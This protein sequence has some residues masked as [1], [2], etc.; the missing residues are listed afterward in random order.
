MEVG[1]HQGDPIWLGHRFAV[2]FDD[3]AAVFLAG[4]D[5]GEVGVDVAGH[6]GGGVAGFQK[7]L[8]HAAEGAVEIDLAVPVAQQWAVK[9]GQ[10][11][12]A[13]FV[14]AFA[15]G[16]PHAV[17]VEGEAVFVADVKSAVGAFE[18]GGLDDAGD[19]PGAVGAFGFFVPAELGGGDG[20]AGFVGGAVAEFHGQDAVLGVFY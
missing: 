1:G 8:R 14:L 12:A 13:M 19:V 6:A 7:L 5:F 2:E 15:G 11:V 20:G 18:P 4:V 16:E 17:V 9:C 10:V 3:T